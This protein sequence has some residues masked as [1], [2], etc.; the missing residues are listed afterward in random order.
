MFENYCLQKYG[1]LSVKKRKIW[2]W[3]AVDRSNNKTVGW[4]RNF[5]GGAVIAVFFAIA[6]FIYAITNDNST[7][8]VKARLFVKTDMLREFSC[9]NVMVVGNSFWEAFG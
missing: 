2:V 6:I 5:V 1:I 7:L 8:I 9:T 4:V 3:R